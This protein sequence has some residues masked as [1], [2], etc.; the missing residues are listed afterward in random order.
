MTLLA[1][2]LVT[3]LVEGDFLVF[4]GISGFFKATFGKIAIINV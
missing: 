2:R 4:A 3:W 1:G